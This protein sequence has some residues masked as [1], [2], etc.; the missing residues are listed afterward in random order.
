LRT[1][2]F[3]ILGAPRA[4]TTTLYDLARR[5]PEI[6][7]SPH[8]EPSFLAF[9]GRRYPNAGPGDETYVETHDDYLALFSDAGEEPIVGESSTLY[10]SSEHAVDCLR[11]HSPD[12][13]L[14]AILRNPADRAFSNYM[15]HVGQGRETLTFEE[16]LDAEDERLAS[17]WSPAWGYRSLGFY[18]AQLDRWLAAFPP[19]RLLVLLYDDLVTDPEATAR[20]LWRFLGVDPSFAPRPERWSPSGRPRSTR[21]HAALWRQDHPVKR[22]L[23]PFLPRRVRQRLLQALLR[24]NLTAAE[25]AAPTRA[26]LLRAYESDIERLETLLGKDLRYWRDP[27]AEPRAGT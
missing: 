5:H 24:R 6:W 9:E 10:L 12:A 22:A 17:G 16:A 4:G 2:N 18:G 3:F 15:L 1:P 11:R 19:E 20:S 13:R 8:K 27:A 23:R 26:E 7:M 21:L 25:M 14:V